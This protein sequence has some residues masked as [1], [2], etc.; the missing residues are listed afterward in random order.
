MSPRDFLEKILGPSSKA[1]E[2]LL[3]YGLGGVV[4]ARATLAWLKESPD[5]DLFCGCPMLYKSEDGF[6]GLVEC[7]GGNYLFVDSTPE[8][9][10]AALIASLGLSL[11]KS[12]TKDLDLAKLGHSLDLLAK[13]QWKTP[14][15]PLLGQT[16]K[17]LAPVAPIQPVP[18][19][20]QIKTAWRVSGL[21]TA[22]PLPKED[23]KAMIPNPAP[24]KPGLPKIKLSEKEMGKKCGICGKAQTDG[25]KFVGCS[26]FK[27]MA[28]CVKSEKINSG[29]LLSFGEGWD[30]E[31][32]VTLFESVG[33]K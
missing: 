14:D 9:A 10:T 33:R 19:P 22:P 4:V 17:P 11:D 27:G 23:P 28:S 12:F 26:C 30:S 24:V 8:H 25:E 5:G 15:K 20:P 29:L 18:A 3:K 2:P 13:A 6:S 21:P 32:I 1:L 31:A 7:A 16:A